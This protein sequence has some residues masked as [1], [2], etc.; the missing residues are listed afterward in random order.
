MATPIYIPKLGMTMVEAKLVEWKAPEGGRIEQGGIVLVIETEKVTWNVEAT[1]SGFVYPMVAAGIKAKVGAVVGQIAETVEELEALRREGPGAAVAEVVAPPPPAR[2][3]PQPSG[4]ARRVLA[5]P[6][7][8]RLAKEL[9]I[10]LSL[11]PGSGPE[12]QIKEA[13]VAA[14]QERVAA[15]PKVTPVAKEMARQAGL[16]LSAV[17]GTGEGGKITKDDVARA[18]QPPAPALVVE[19]VPARGVREVPYDGMRRV[20]ADNLYKC[21]QNTAQVTVFAEVDATES[22]A[23]LDAVRRERAKE[24]EF[25]VSLNDLL[26]LAACRALKQVPAMNSNLVGDRILQFDAVHMG[27]A[28]AVPNGLVVPVLKDADRLGLVEIAREARVLAR[29]AREGTLSLD[30]MLGG[31]F[32]IS[33]MSMFDVDGSTPILKAPE[34]GIL[35]V[36]RVKQKPAVHEGEICIRSMMFLSL[37]FDHRVVDGVPPARFLQQIGQYVQN[38]VMMLA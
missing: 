21:L 32:T 6:A 31:T 1:A 25:K 13:D 14:Y 35:G 16:D 2:E 28:V 30:E 3:V 10:D 12:G 17:Q 33:N 34:T 20:I 38:P 15:G 26:V 8:R 19:E 22:L 11:V 27:I 36:G 23:F 4:E 9:G 7:A 29:K 24:P 18:L 37:T 5:S